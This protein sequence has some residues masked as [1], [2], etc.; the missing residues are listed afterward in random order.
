M[1]N[2]ERHSLRE[3]Q[4]QLTRERLLEAAAELLADDLELGFRAVAAR[5]GV[6]APTVYRH[7]ESQE[8][9]IE[10]L[11]VHL[12]SRLGVKAHPATLDDYIAML[13]EIFG[14]F[15]A[16]GRFMLAYMRAPRAVPIRERNRRRREVSI[17]AGLPRH[18]ALL[19]P[20]MAQRF[21]GLM[22]T[23]GSANTWNSLGSVTDL[24]GADAGR[25]VAWAMRA[26]ET[27]VKSDPASF[28]E[29]FTPSTPNPER[30]P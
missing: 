26:L 7:F 20:E 21:A 10:A 9:L 29:A 28:I 13:P 11:L 16:H 27:A 23:L 24:R 1:A 12:E 25:A 3:D 17:R 30:S 5:A 6:S 19:H 18:P 2:L 4:L 15:E 8:A 22:L 14:A